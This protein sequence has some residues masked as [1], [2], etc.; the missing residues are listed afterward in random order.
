MLVADI[1]WATSEI[2]S[3]DEATYKLFPANETEMD[4]HW[5]LWLKSEVLDGLFSGEFHPNPFDTSIDSVLQFEAE[6]KE[7]VL[8]K[9]LYQIK[10]FTNT[11]PV[12]I[13]I[14]PL[15]IWARLRKLWISAT[16][17]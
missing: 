6:A 3:Y 2:S 7:T 4:E 14:Y 8:K 17:R 13:R 15:I 1:D 5:R 16:M 10:S 9:E 12:T 11:Q